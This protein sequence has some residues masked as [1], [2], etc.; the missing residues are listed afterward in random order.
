MSRAELERLD[1]DTL[2]RR[3]E[4]A[5]VTR[6]R[7]LTR[8]ELVDELLIRSCAD[9]E[10]RERVRGF[11]GLARD[12]LARVV[13]RGLHLPDAAERIRTIRAPPSPRRAAQAALPTVTLAEI[14]AAQGHRD[15]A[16]ETLE[17]VLSREP[18]HAAARALLVQLQDATYPMPPPRMPPEQQQDEGTSPSGPVDSDGE[19]IRV[20]PSSHGGRAFDKESAS[21]EPSH[22]LDDAPLPPRY[23]VDECVAIPVDPK[24][25]YVYWEVRE[26]TLEYV[27]VTRPEGAIGLRVVVVVPTWDGPRSSVRDY[28]AR[29]PLDELF[30]RDLPP[31]CVVRAAIG[32]RHGDAFVPIAHSP[33]LE[34]PPNGPSPLVADVL[35]RWTPHGTSPV[36]PNDRD[37]AAIDRALGRVRREAAQAWQG[38][39]VVAV[40]GPEGSSEKWVNAPSS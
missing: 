23:D 6:A 13:E 30:V 24:T 21:R 10:T 19:P 1:R 26:R 29:A 34:T 40:D 39:E 9:E 22:V 36:T 4:E 12:L 35:V 31:G 5:G 2:I 25:L 14:Y 17:S 38:R 32:W 11:F 16:V 20:L 33:A 7:I 15:R 3:A 27:R 18:D 28:D 8:P 37:A